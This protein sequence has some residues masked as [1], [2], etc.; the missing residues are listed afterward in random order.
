MYLR[1]KSPA[2]HVSL[3]AVPHAVVRVRAK[4]RLLAGGMVAASLGLVSQCD[5]VLARDRDEL[6][7][8]SAA[9]R[10]LRQQPHS[11][12]PLKIVISIAKQRLAVYEG[13]NKIAEAPVSTG[14]S[15]HATPTGIF[16]II[17]KNRV[18]YSNLYNDAPMPFM[19][20][21]TWSGVALHAGHLPGYPASHGCIRMPHGF[22][23][24]LFGMTRIGARVVVARNDPTPHSFAHAMMPKPLPRDDAQPIASNAIEQRGTDSNVNLLLGVS[25]A[26]AASVADTGIPTRRTRESVARERAAEI[27]E[28]KEAVKRNEAQ[29]ASAVE[30]NAAATR[31]AD[32]AKSAVR[33]AKLET[34]EIARAIEKTERTAKGAEAQLAMLIRRNANVDQAGERVLETEDQLEARLLALVHEADALRADRADQEIELGRLERTA[35]SLEAARVEAAS[36][37]SR[38]A[39]LLKDAKD[40]LVAAERAFARRDLPPAIFVSRKTGKLYVRQG[41][42]PILE[43]P[44]AFEHP[45]APVGTHVYTALGYTE[46]EASLSWSV[47]SVGDAAASNDDERSARRSKSAAAKPAPAEPQV[48]VPTTAAHAIE[49]LKLSEDTREQLAEIIKP[50][51]SLIISDLP[52]SSETGKGTDF[53]VLTR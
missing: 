46:G 5:G 24:Q 38:A 31:A 17:Q 39:G 14:Q 41:F 3:P 6:P 40:E 15:G 11:G 32:D 45:D 9:S 7:Y 34:E 1:I 49:R 51:A 20:R 44:V 4:G 26:T 2:S 10:H 53:I 16:S 52:I 36:A 35:A 25:T 29:H 21:I 43:A 33:R 18:H 50:G 13:L 12:S 28:I 19:Q 37:L 47:I 48:K 22:A 23:S 42:E 27:A 30:R 8:R